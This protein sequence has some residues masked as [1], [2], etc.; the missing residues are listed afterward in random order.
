MTAQ[1]IDRVKAQLATLTESYKKQ[2]GPDYDG[3]GT[4]TAKG[5]IQWQ[6]SHY[7]VMLKR[8]TYYPVAAGTGG[9]DKVRVF[10]W[11]KPSCAD[12]LK[13]LAKGD[14]VTLSGRL[15]DVTFYRIA[16]GPKGRFLAPLSRPVGAG[17]IMDLNMED[18]LAG[19]QAI[20]QALASKPPAGTSGKASVEASAAELEKQAQGKLSL[21]L[22]Y[23]ANGSNT[24]AAG[25]LQAI[26]A[27]YPN[28]ASAQ[29]A[30]EELESINS[31]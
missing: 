8:A 27:D 30:K 9:D 14:P 26:I 13:G 4:A 31:K 6:I 25:L 1:D 15:F 2:T 20:K 12:Y 11:I 17:A 22:S 18:C 10:A 3:E 21:A 19:E 7:N 28:T 29:R 5:C 16:A 24:K 23:K